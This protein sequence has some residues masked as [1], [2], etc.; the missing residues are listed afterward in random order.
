MR[1]YHEKLLYAISI[2][3]YSLKTNKSISYI[4]FFLL[5]STSI[6]GQNLIVNPDAE[7]DPISNGWTQVSGNWV[8]ATEITPQNG[9]YHFG[10]GDSAGVSEIY[11]DIDVSSFANDIDAGG[12][13]FSF[14]GYISTWNG[15]DEGR[16]II[17]Y[18]NSSNVVLSSYDTGLQIP[19]VWTKFS[20]T[21]V[22][23]INTRIVRVR[24]LSTRNQGNY[25]DG[26]IDNLELYAFG[27]PSTSNVFPLYGNVGIGTNNPDA[28]LAVN[29]NIHTKEVKVDL[30]SWPDYV[31]ED[32]YKLPTLKSIEAHIKEE[33]H[34]PNIPKASFVKVN[35]IYLGQMNAK[36][37]E[38]IEELTL[39]TIQQENHIK[40]LENSEQTLKERVGKLENTVDRLEKIIAKYHRVKKH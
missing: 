16:I 32:T 34:L 19:T 29:G 22:A 30:A 5:I 37:L 17:E 12:I 35:G 8:S 28:K 14:S 4:L 13:N 7:L 20:D 23:N 21:R 3:I 31:F 40:V 18:R 15:L 11:Q 25:S 26:Y 2:I 9:V 1:Y 33:G 6:N 27:N 36:L 39:Y 24:L 10:A 38:K